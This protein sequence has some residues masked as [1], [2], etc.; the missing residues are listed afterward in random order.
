M[1]LSEATP[2][3]LS[4]VIYLASVYEPDEPCQIYLAT[5]AFTNVLKVGKWLY[6]CLGVMSVNYRD[7][8]Q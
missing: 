5:Q 4:I 7:L 8:E 6:A 1:K 3:C 2:K